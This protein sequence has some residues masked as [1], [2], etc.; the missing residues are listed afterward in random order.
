MLVEEREGR[1]GPVEGVSTTNGPLA[2]GHYAIVANAGAERIT[3]EYHRSHFVP[4]ML[5]S[6]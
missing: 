4:A 5:S 6:R 3:V 2:R 1:E